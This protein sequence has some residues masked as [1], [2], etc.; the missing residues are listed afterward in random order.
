MPDDEIL[1]RLLA[2]NLAR[3]QPSRGA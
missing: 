1:R 3:K 2:Q